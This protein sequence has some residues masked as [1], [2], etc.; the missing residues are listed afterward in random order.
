MPVTIRPVTTKR[1]LARF[2]ALPRRIYAGDPRFVAPLDHDRAQLIAPTQSAFWT[3][4]EA[5]YWI[6]LDGKGR[7]VGRISAQIDRLATGPQ[8]EGAGVFGWLDA[9]DH[10]DVGAALLDTARAWLAGKGKS[11]MRGPF[12]LSINAESG[13]LIEGFE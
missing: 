8:H 9:V 11:L 2:L 5:A 12:P 3:H 10:A 1:D 4:G 6:A 13:L 7:E